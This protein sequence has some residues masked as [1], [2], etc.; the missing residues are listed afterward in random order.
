MFFFREVIG[1]VE[2][3]MTDRQSGHSEGS[4]AS[5]NMGYGVGD[6]DD[7]VSRNRALLCQQLHIAHNNLYVPTQVHGAD[8][9][10]VKNAP[11]LAGK[12]TCDALITTEKDIAI[13]VTTADCVPVLIFDEASSVA[14]AVHAGWR[15]VV[16]R[17]VPEVINQIACH[18]RIARSA[19]QVMVFPCISQKNFEVGEE[20]AVEFEKLS[21][22]DIDLVVDRTKFGSKPH[23]NL[24][25]AVRQQ[26]I[27]EGVCESRIKVFSECTFSNPDT[28]YSARR[29]GVK[30]GRMLTGVIL[31]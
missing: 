19:L 6:V 22:S 8:S 11:T 4:Y 5:S 20:V 10:W 21:L 27:A 16:K 30:T 13:A 31:H 17:I 2:C 28:F 15:G 3:F 26:A 7:N 1:S 25:E 14:A 23:I 29:D 24:S 18:L 12:I 9:S